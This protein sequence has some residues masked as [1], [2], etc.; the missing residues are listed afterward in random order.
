MSKATIVVRGCEDALETIVR[1][2]S[3]GDLAIVPC[4][5]IYG[6]VGKAVDTHESLRMV[7]GRPEDKPFIQ[8]ATL[9]MV[10]QRIAGLLDSAI[11]ACW[12][13]PLTAILDDVSGAKTA[14]RVPADDFLQEVLERLRQPLYSTSVNFSGEPALL[15]FESIAERFSDRVALIVKSGERQGTIPSTIIDATAKPFKL[16]RQG[17]LDVSELLAASA[18][19]GQIHDIE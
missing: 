6:I 3:N 12:P 10:K 5:T 9:A 4:D 18:R 1:V 8:L 7:K 13:G 19:T 2:L 15:D 11:E 14:F 17:V 16:V